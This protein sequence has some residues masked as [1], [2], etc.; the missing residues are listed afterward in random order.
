MKRHQEKCTARLENLQENLNESLHENLQE[1]LQYS[2][3]NTN[4]SHNN[5]QGGA[6]APVYTQGGAAGQSQVV[7]SQIKTDLRPRYNYPKGGPSGA[8]SE[9][10]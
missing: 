9:W 1:T 7:Y 8:I 3:S 10:R 6:Q 2:I 4:P 5:P